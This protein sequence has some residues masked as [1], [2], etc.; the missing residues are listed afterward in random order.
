MKKEAEDGQTCAFELLASLAG[1]LLQESASSSAS[2][3]ASEGNH[4]PAIGQGVSEQ[5]RQD[6]VKPSATEC[7][8]LGNCA[9][10]IL[11]T[12]VASQNSS[13]KCLAQAEADAILE[14][15]SVS[16]KSDCWDRAEAE[17]KFEICKWENKFGHCSNILTE[18]PKGFRE[19]YDGNI[20]NEFNQ[21][22]KAGSPGID[23]PV[24]A[25]KCSLKDPEELCGRSH[26]LVDSKSNVKSPFC[27]ESF[28][29]ASFSRHGNDNNLGFRDDDENFLRC[30]KVSTKSKAFRSPQRIAHRRIG[31]LLTS[32]YWKAAPKLKD[33]DLSRSGKVAFKLATVYIRYVVSLCFSLKAI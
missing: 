24:L 8:L 9:E 17:V 21:Q 16:S 6:Q 12:E 26:V 22:E 5:E 27:R 33:C 3:N 18:A 11:M 30:S 29:N 20:K 19:P 31:K 23:G 10:S 14:C 25:N 2:S 4:C 15:T 32:K 1:K 28:P 7:I 13:Q